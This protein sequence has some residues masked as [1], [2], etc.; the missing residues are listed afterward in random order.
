M[1]TYQAEWL[2]DD[3]VVRAQ[4]DLYDAVMNMMET[5]GGKQAVTKQWKQ[6][7]QAAR[8]VAEAKDLM[9]RRNTNLWRQAAD[10]GDTIPGNVRATYDT[11]DHYISKLQWMAHRVLDEH[12][13][14]TAYASLP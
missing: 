10:D 1:R 2:H 8:A 4:G 7:G 13:V 11:V 14:V 5:E 6:A 12:S 3:R 9:G